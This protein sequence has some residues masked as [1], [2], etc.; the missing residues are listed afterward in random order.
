[1]FVFLLEVQFICQ[2][3]DLLSDVLNWQSRNMVFSNF[4]T[5]LVEVNTTLALNV[6]NLPQVTNTS[7]LSTW[8]FETNPSGL[9][10][11]DITL[12][13]TFHNIRIYLS[14]TFAFIS[15]VNFKRF[16]VRTL[17]QRAHLDGVVEYTDYISAEGENPHQRVSWIWH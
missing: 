1:M 5:I 4:Y 12:F 9:K 16:F 10:I 17:N 15:N 3:R 11:K 8:V 2:A 7:N 6:K 13:L 14:N